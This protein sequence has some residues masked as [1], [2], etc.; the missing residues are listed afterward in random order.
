M[1]SCTYAHSC[2]WSLSSYLFMQSRGKVARN[3]KS[4]IWHMSFGS[5]FWFLF[6]LST[7]NKSSPWTCEIA[8]LDA[9]ELSK[10]LLVR[11]LR[12]PYCL[13][14]LVSWSCAPGQICARWILLASS[15]PGMVP[16]EE[17]CSGEHTDGEELWHVIKWWAPRGNLQSLGTALRL[18]LSSLG[19]AHY[20]VAASWK[21]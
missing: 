1:Y 10:L 12:F 16:V 19:D 2:F 7:Q 8:S 5:H 9:G 6:C 17:S 13:S 20:L 11:G 15:F 3:M 21:E 14:V 18:V 4:H